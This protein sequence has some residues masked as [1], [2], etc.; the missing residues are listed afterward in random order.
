MMKKTLAH[1]ESRYYFANETMHSLLT[2][3]GANVWIWSNSDKVTFEIS[4]K[5]LTLFFMRYANDVDT[6]KISPFP[7]PHG[8]DLAIRIID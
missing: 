1:I 2:E 7:N 8:N 4:E 3:L 6:L 5:K